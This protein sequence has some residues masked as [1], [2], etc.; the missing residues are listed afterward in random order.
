MKDKLLKAFLDE[1]ALDVF[2]SVQGANQ[3]WEVDP[4]DVV[5]IHDRARAV[6][7]RTFE[8]VLGADAAQSGRSLVLLGDAGCGKTHL[9]RAFRASVQEE[10]RGYFAYL[11]L[12]TAVSDYRRYFLSH[13]VDSLTKHYNQKREEPGLLRLSDQLAGYCQ[14]PILSNL[15]DPELPNDGVQTCAIEAVNSLMLDPQFSGLDEQLLRALVVLQARSDPR[16]QRGVSAWLRCEDLPKVDRDFLGI[17]TP[18]FADDDPMRT[19]RGLAQVMSAVGCGLVIAVDQMEESFTEND[20]GEGLRRIAEVLREV[21]EHSPSVLIV[22]S[23]LRNYW[24]V[25]R[26]TLNKPMLDRIEVDPEPVSLE[27][28]RDAE[29][30]RQVIQ[31]R[32]EWLFNEADLEIDPL[33]PTYPFPAK[34]VERLGQQR[35]RTR[36]LISACRLWQEAAIRAQALP[37]TFP[38]ESSG[39]AERTDRLTGSL[40]S[41]DRA[42]NDFLSTWK[43]Q[44]PEEGPAVARLLGTLCQTIG[45]E[46]VEVQAAM[47]GPYLR[48]TT[49]A[50]AQVVG[51]CNKSPRGGGLLHELEALADARRGAT[52]VALR[53]AEFPSGKK[54]QSVQTLAKMIKEGGS[55]FVYDDSEFR[56]VTAFDAF[57]RIE[58]DHPAFAEWRRTRRPMA[59]LRLVRDGLGLALVPRVV[60]RP[61]PVGG[62]SRQ[63][64]LE[65]DSNGESQAKADHLP[66]AVLL[67]KSLSKTPVPVVLPL[68]DLTRHTAILGSPGSGKTTLALSIVEQLLSQKISVLLLDRKGDLAGYARPDTPAPLVSLLKKVTLRLY[69]PGAAEGNP[70]SIPLVPDRS[71]LKAADLGEAADATAASLTGMLGYKPAQGNL[72]VMLS[73][74][75]LTLLEAGETDIDLEAIIQLLESGDESYLSRVQRYDTKLL[76]RLIDNLETLKHGARRL[77]SKEGDQ[78]DVGALLGPAPTPRLTIVSTKF[79]DQE[80]SIFFVSQLLTAVSRWMSRNPSPSGRLQAVVMLDEADIYAPAT[81]EPPSKSRVMDLLRRGRSAGLG[82]MIATQNPGDLDYRGRENIKTWL[83]GKVTETNSKEKVRPL[84]ADAHAATYLDRL[85]SFQV[86]Q[87]LLARSPDPL[88]FQ[89]NPSLLHTEQLSEDEIRQHASRLKAL[90]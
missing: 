44:V 85:S 54:T 86:G 20:G 46:G 10:N 34:D 5:E 76:R 36:D 6:F 32:L 71:Q 87:F 63:V 45:S 66:D 4:F 90:R 23:C 84:L 13:L 56:Q 61:Q 88:T 83:I 18:R 14:N 51:V 67:G 22:L 31:K 9:L 12:R 11:Q 43:G 59:S 24:Q 35:L 58:A 77:L 72:A 62:G 48:L 82:M 70:L 3:I 16:Y 52:A 74:A 50:G 73:Q 29:E 21:S 68:D 55:R 75:V 81:R 27:N 49:P 65:P 26:Q 17:L 15:Y 42:W 47:D 33:D 40:E 30:C 57:H 89:A 69:T 41:V 53:A 2:G 38:L 60:V 8:R 25:A 37:A 28:I 80:K 64:G 7:E 79:L 1:S 78:L 19:V 39:S